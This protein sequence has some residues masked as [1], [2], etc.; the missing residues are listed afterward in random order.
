MCVTYS[1]LD[2]TRQ[3][4]KYLHATPIA[5]IAASA[6]KLVRARW[7]QHY[8]NNAFNSVCFA[9]SSRGI[10]GATPVETMHVFCKG[11]IEYVTFF[12]LENVPV[13]RKAAIDRLAIQF[14]QTH[15]QT[16]RKAYPG[17][18]FSRGITNLTKISARERLGLVFLFEILAQF[19]EGW[20][21]FEHAFFK[22]S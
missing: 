1:D 9:D 18:D 13:S 6:D 2:A 12:V 3:S 4:C 20:E 22:K 14:H 10:F 19:D 5:M 21:I 17:T 15:R 7:S 16:H 11:L 8:L